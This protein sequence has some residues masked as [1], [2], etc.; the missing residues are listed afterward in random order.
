MNRV[1]V[2]RRIEQLEKMLTILQGENPKWFSVSLVACGACGVVIE[3]DIRCVQSCRWNGQSVASRRDLKIY[4]C[5]VV[6][7]KPVSVT[8]VRSVK[9]SVVP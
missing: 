3:D 5:A 6:A 7:E 1:L 4:E 2:Q 9:V 8:T